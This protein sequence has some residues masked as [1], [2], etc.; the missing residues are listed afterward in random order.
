VSAPAGWEPNTAV[1]GSQWAAL[2]PAVADA[3][4]TLAAE[5]LWA[6]SGRRF[7]T[8]T[9]TLAPYL[10]VRAPCSAGGP[11]GG[12]ALNAAA[13]TA[14]PWG[15]A[16][17]RS[18]VFR[19]PGPV[20]A[21]TE[22]R[23]AG[24]VMDPAHWKADPDGRLVWTAPAE[25]G[26]GWP[27]GQDVYAE[28]PA[29]TVTYTRG[30]PVPDAGKVALARYAHEIAKGM[31][32]APGDRLPGRAR[33]ITRAG[34]N[35]TMVA[36]EDPANAGLT[37]IPLVDSWLRAVNPHRLSSPSRLYAPEMSRHR[38]LSIAGAGS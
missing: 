2:D 30:I 35:I 18:T 9:V 17:T 5:E 10:P 28:P 21:V 8:W 6:L 34:T 4:V 33:D 24:A 16:A 19:L 20:V 31:A 29:W 7:G 25:L 36:P 37:G 3:A 38:V 22:V 27:V 1:L 32:A 11:W 12:Y 14:T 26:A 15:V 13:G 23:L